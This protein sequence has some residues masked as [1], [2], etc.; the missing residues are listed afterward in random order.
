MTSLVV[1][2][3]DEGSGTTEESVGT[4]GDD[5]TLTLS[6]LTGGT[7]ETL[8]TE[9]LGLGQGFT[10]KGGLVH[11]DINGFD[12]TTIGGTDITVLESDDVTRNK[13][14]RF[15]LSPG[16]VSLNSGLGGE[17][18]HEGLD[19]V[20]SVSLFDE[21]DSRVDEQKQDN[22]DEV[23]PIRG[24]TPTV[25]KGDG[26]KGSTLHDPGKRVPHEGEELQEDVL[27]LLL[28]LVGTEDTDTVLGLGLSETTLITLEELE[29]LLHD[30]VLDIDLVLVVQVGSG[31]LDLGYKP[32]SGK[33]IL[34]Q[35]TV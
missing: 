30:D 3:S 22:T 25:G 5:D 2:L 21:T 28:E 15:D 11:G 8:V 23:L 26:D 9:L 32:N 4:G 35:T 1:V 12:K 17:G 33:M 34:N 16:T 19:S 7:R 20:T 13:L 14:G 27:L 6:L 10:G 29:D 31:E 18:I 24:L